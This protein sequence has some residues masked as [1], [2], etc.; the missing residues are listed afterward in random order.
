MLKKQL[1]EHKTSIQISCHEILAEFLSVRGTIIG[2][3]Q[4][5]V[6]FNQKSCIVTG[7]EHGRR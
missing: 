2:K 5:P 7:M 3:G 4:L 1:E 6:R